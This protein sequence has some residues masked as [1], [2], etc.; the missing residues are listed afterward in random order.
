M[1]AMNAM[2]D[3][4]RNVEL[5]RAENAANIE[6]LSSTLNVATWKAKRAKLALDDHINKHGCSA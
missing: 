1:E 3:A 4:Q 2:Y 5:A 6:R